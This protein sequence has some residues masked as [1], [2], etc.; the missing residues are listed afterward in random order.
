[1][2]SQETHFERQQGGGEGLKVIFCFVYRVVLTIARVESPADI[3]GH[4]G[5]TEA[6]V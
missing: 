3:W 4:D 1:M 2:Y 6:H 5:I